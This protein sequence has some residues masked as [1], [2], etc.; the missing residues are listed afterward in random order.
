[1]AQVKRRRQT[2]HR[3]N[4]AGVVVARGRT[5][6][7]PTAAER[8]ESAK[9]A[10]E[11][12]ERKAQRYDRPPTWKGALTRALVAAA[13]VLVVSLLILRTKPVQAI[14]LF[15][16]VTLVYVPMSYYTDL[17]L[18]RRRVRRKEQQR[19]AIRA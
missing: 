11:A 6:R 17:W 1:V 18:H 19:G 8:S 12:K 4:A 14:A 15:P 5:G 10:A 3:G 7:K 16:V 13:V 9:R 2:K